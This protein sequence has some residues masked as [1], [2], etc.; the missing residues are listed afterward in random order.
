L[1]LSAGLPIAVAKGILAGDNVTKIEQAVK[2]AV[3]AVLG[4]VMPLC[5]KQNF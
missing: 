2:Q 1:A 4:F 3:E 5:D